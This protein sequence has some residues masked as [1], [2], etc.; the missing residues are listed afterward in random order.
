[1][2][3]EQ[4]K[5][6]EMMRNTRKYW[7]VD[8]LTE[9]SVGVLIFL[10]G[11]TYYLSFLIPN[12]VIRSLM[13]GLGQPV[14][15]IAGSVVIG[16]LV[17]KIKETL[18]FPRTGYLSFRKRKSRKINRILYGAVIGLMVGVVVGFFTAIIP[19]RIV[20][21]V[22]SLFMAILIVFIGYQ[23]NVTRFYVISAFTA[24][25]GGVLSALNPPGVLPFVVLFMGV[26][27]IW[28][29]SG[30]WTLAS[31]LRNTSPAEVIDE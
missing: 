30:G 10:I 17:K 2:N 13:L 28:L 11:L 22:T 8:G 6:N 26:G 20:P 24:V 15:I 19:E 31:Y 23:N 21:L 1:M 5:I 14:L 18:T 27:F 9:I 16:K 7:Y 29:I 4:I 25:W 3:Q 12:V